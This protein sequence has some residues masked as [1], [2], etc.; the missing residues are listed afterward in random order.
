MKQLGA[1]PL[2][3]ISQCLTCQCL[4]SDTLHVKNVVNSPNP[5]VKRLPDYEW[6][7]TLISCGLLLHTHTHTVSVC[8]SLSLSVS[9][10]AC[11]CVSLCLSVCLSVSLSPS[12]LSDR[13]QFHPSSDSAREPPLRHRFQSQTKSDWRIQT[14]ALPTYGSR[15]IEIIHL[16]SQIGR[17]RDKRHEF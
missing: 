10:S 6:Q 8:L 5:A 15:R 3:S 7:A 9:L 2:N 4:C 12:L 13:H 17:K 14:E 11:V 1:T 16:F